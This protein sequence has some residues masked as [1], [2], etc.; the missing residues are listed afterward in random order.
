MLIDC[1]LHFRHQYG[2][3]ATE[4]IMYGKRP[5]V[6]ILHTR[7]Y[8]CNARIAYTVAKFFVAKFYVAFCRWRQLL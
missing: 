1:K 6:S 4:T 8:G 3:I 7:L 5:N 2:K